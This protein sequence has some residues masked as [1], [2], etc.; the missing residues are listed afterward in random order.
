[1]TD[2]NGAQVSFF[3]E[4]FLAQSGFFSVRA[5]PFTKE[6]AMGL[7]WHSFLPNQEARIGTIKHALRFLLH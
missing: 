2:E 5:N 3:G 7:D 6:S 1:V 4:A